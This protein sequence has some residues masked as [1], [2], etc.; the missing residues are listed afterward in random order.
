MRTPEQFE[1]IVT[2]NM[3][4]DILSDLT[5]GLVGGLGFAPG[6]NLG[7]DIAIFEAV[8]GS[9]PKYTNK[10]VINPSA[11]L[12]SGVMMLRHLDEFD[13]ARSIENAV[14]V[15]LEQGL[16]T[17]D[18]AQA[19]SASTT[20]FTEAVIK[21]LGKRSERWGAREHKALRMPKVD[22]ARDYVRPKTVRTIGTDIF[23][24][25]GISP[26]ELG[27]SLEE[28]AAGT[29]LKLKMISNRGTKVYPSM[30]AMTDCVDHWRCRFVLREAGGN[31][32]D[33][34]FFDLLARVAQKHAWMHVEKLRE[35]DGQLGYSLAQ[36]ED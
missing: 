22:G 23:V 29:P 13:A 20:A 18:V 6:A 33:P 32:A 8:H 1:V 7:E 25:S 27:K 34:V 16:Y 14:I 28:I 30:G 11:V 21:N 4:G 15:T 5:S 31:L 10:N 26:D 19:G 36:G 3:N 12:L 35:F 9:A 24:E 17:R 2:S